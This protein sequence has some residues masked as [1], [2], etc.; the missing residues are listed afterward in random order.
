MTRAVFGEGRTIIWLASYLKSGNTWLR[1]LLTA[2]LAGPDQFD[3]NALIG[4]Q[5]A[6]L[7]EAID[8]HTGITSANCSPDELIPYQADFFRS[9]AAEAAAPCFIKTHSAYRKSASGVSLFPAEASAGVVHIVRDPVDVVPSYAHHE[10]RDFD[11]I[12]QRM[13][14]PDAAMDLWPGRSS[15]MVPQIVSSWS[16]NV[17]S[18]A[19]Q[20][21]IPLMLLRYEDL[22]ADACAAFSKVLRFCGIEVDPAR[23]AAAVD[24]CRLD[25]LQKDEAGTGFTEKPSPLREFFRSGR[26]GDGQRKLSRDQIAKVT[27]DHAAMMKQLHYAVDLEKEQL[28]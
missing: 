16:E 12:I 25:R 3:L 5:E 2:Y 24:R 1:S 14:D 10:G 21:E 11:H 15:M 4:G 17:S 19:E 20:R 13:A 7:R 22:Q 9:L 18:W 28:Q 26:V 23:V 6:F 8:D 27:R